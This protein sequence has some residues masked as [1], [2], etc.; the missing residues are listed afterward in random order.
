MM[1]FIIA[2]NAN[3]TVLNWNI[4]KLYE[5]KKNVENSDVLKTRESFQL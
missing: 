3:Q 4:I 1:L 2:F 5:K